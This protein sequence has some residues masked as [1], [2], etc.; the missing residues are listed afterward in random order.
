MAPVNLLDRYTR[1]LLNR[2]L[3]DDLSVVEVA[4]VEDLLLTV[5]DLGLKDLVLVLENLE[6]GVAG[7]A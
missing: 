2:A 5:F 3:R 4:W 1:L 7:V 6:V